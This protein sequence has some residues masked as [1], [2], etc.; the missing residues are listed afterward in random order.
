MLVAVITPRCD[1]NHNCWG[2][3]QPAGYFTTTCTGTVC[4]IDPEVATTVTLYV[5]AGVPNCAAWDDVPLFEG[6][7]LL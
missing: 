4:C 5:P 7:R 2:L 6:G 1:R 3:P